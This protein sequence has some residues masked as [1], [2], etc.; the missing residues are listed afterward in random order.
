MLSPQSRASSLSAVATPPRVG[1]RI[2]R[3][4][5]PA[6]STTASTIGSTERVSDERSASSSRS[7]RASRIVTAVIADGPREQDA[8]AWPHIAGVDA[9]IRQDATD[10]GGGDVHPV[11]LAVLHHLGVAADDRHS[12]A[13]RCVGHGAHLVLEDRRRQPRFEHK[14]HDQA[15]GSGA[16]DRKVVDRAV[17]R[18]L[19][20]RSAVEAQ[21]TD[22]EA[23]G[24]ERDAGA[25]DRRH[26]RRPRAAHADLVTR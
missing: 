10:T 3:M 4:P 26:A 17:D 7:P 16:R 15:F 13:A 12:G 19:A 11:R 5:G 22:H 6:A 21:R 25:V 24:S 1:S 2:Q 23:V 9:H 18:E 20:D 8:I 14:G